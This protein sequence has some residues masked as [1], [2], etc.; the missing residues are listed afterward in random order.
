MWSSVIRLA[1]RASR[2][3]PPRPRSDATSRARVRRC[4][5]F[6]RYSTGTPVDCEICAARDT[7]FGVPVRRSDV[8]AIDII[9]S[10]P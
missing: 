7:P 6:R 9:A 10:I 5:T 2:N 4:K 3:P 1:A 8:L